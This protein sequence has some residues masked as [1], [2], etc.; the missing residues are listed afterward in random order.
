MLYRAGRPSWAKTVQGAERMDRESG[1]VAGRTRGP[2][3]AGVLDH[4]DFDQT[5]GIVV[6]PRKVTTGEQSLR[7]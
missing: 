5:R 3:E 1:A 6:R 4:L 2:S 7:G